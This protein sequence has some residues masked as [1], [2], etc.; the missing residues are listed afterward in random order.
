[1]EELSPYQR[2]ENLRRATKNDRLQQDAEFAERRNREF[3]SIE[4]ERNEKLREFLARIQPEEDNLRITEASI[5][6]QLELTQK[7]ELE[8]LLAKHKEE[9]VARVR[10]STAAIAQLTDKNKADEDILWSYY[11]EK[12]LHTENEFKDMKKGLLE[13][14][15]LED[16]K[17]SEDAFKVVDQQSD[18]T[19]DVATHNGDIEMSRL[20]STAR[21]QSGSTIDVATH[22]GDIRTSTP[23]STGRSQQHLY[24][25]PTRS[26]SAAAIYESPLGKTDEVNMLRGYSQTPQSHPRQAS[27]TPSKRRL[28]ESPFENVTPPMRRKVSEKKKSVVDGTTFGSANS[29]APF[30]P[31]FTST[32]SA[33]NS[34]S[35]PS[36]TPVHAVSISSDSSHS[37]TQSMQNPSQLSGPGSELN[38]G[39]HTPA[40]ITSEVG[41]MY[42]VNNTPSRTTSQRQT[43][44]PSTPESSARASALQSSPLS[45]SRRKTTL[46]DNFEI[47]AVRFN[48]ATGGQYS[49]THEPGDPP[50]WYRLRK[51][52]YEP[53]LKKGVSTGSA[54][55][56][57]RPS[58][59]WSLKHDANSCL[60]YITRKMIGNAGKD[61]WITFKDRVHLDGFL[62]SYRKGWEF[63]KVGEIGSDDEISISMMKKRS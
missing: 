18:L 45:A 15:T 36:A 56:H 29:S 14:R 8:S 35:T 2:L 25:T 31:L 33:N 57:I 28:P 3:A 23:T 44:P 32:T 58:R 51:N 6:A 7:T 12:R 59:I 10:E 52:T 53:V 1:M 62:E 16:Q 5:S 54:E 46:S 9:T 26:V 27:V 61:M 17:L 19:I 24:K 47:V 49:W 11:E 20:T 13:T 50:R 43:L 48:Y 21:S 55:W 37:T 42:N 60:V 34:Q 63:N 4:N 41:D 30:N 39:Y 22:D 38:R 40:N